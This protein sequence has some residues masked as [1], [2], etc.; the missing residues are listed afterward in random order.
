MQGTCALRLASR[1]AEQPDAHRRSHPSQHHASAARAAACR[2]PAGE[3]SGLLRPGRLCNARR[4]TSRTCPPMRPP[5]DPGASPASL[6][7]PRNAAT[8]L[9]M[10]AAAGLTTCTSPALRPAC[11]AGLPRA[12]CSR[13]P[14]RDVRLRERGCGPRNG[15]GRISRGCLGRSRHPA[16]GSSPPLALELLRAGS[17]RGRAR[18]DSRRCGR[19]RPLGR[20]ASRRRTVRIRRRAR[21]PTPC[22]GSGGA[23]CPWPP[24]C[25]GHCGCAEGRCGKSVGRFRRS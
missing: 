5:R 19:S 16:A 24:A 14:L 4:S 17:W 8:S 9:W 15:C 18:G 11:S 7:A 25:R 2:F 10:I 6:S 1:R 3:R 13:R 22:A 12:P 21:P 20:G 23:W